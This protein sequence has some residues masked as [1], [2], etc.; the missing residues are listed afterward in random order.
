MID[1]ERVEHP[2]RLGCDLRADPISR[3]DGDV[4]H[5]VDRA[6]S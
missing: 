3:E 2:N 6:V 4:R 5:A 1:P